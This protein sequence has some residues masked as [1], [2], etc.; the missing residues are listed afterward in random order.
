MRG[1]LVFLISTLAVLSVHA[2]DLRVGYSE[3]IVNLPEK[4]S[5]AGYI[6]RRLVRSSNAAYSKYFR[7][8]TGKMNDSLAKTIV[9][10]DGRQLIFMSTLEVIA[11]EPE[12]KALVEERLRQLINRPLEVNLFATHTHSGPG[13]FVKVKLW[14]QLATDYY[15]A[16]V[17]NHFAD[18]LVESAY[19]AYNSLEKVQ[20]SYVTGSVNGFVFNRRNG[21]YLNPQLNIVKFVNSNNKPVVSILNFPIHGTALGP[22]NLLVSGDLPAMVENKMVEKTNSPF[23]F[24]SGAA[25]DVGPK[26]DE[27]GATSF[28]AT[29]ASSP[30]LESIEKFTNRLADKINVFWNQTNFVATK[31]AIVRSFNIELPPA[32]ADLGSCIKSVLPKPFQW[33]SNFFFRVKLPKE[34][35][36]PMIVN[37]V[38]LAPLTFYMIPGEPIGEVGKEIEKFSV[39]NS[40]DNPMILAL[41][42]SYYGY[43]LSDKEFSRGGYETCNSF[44]GKTYG[45]LFL[46]G[47]QDAV[48]LFGLL[49][50]SN[51]F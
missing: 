49:V 41:A 47:L 1:I 50:K 6:Q 20:M 2:A 14:Q 38:H 18:S 25:G 10:D 26:I 21:S 29:V 4:I 24:F 13:G 11:I 45:S 46:S 12:M 48:N 34:L 3:K 36:R 7:A 51:R 16:D 31:P 44:Y 42:N 30:S 15:F 19:S 9:I 27:S 32:Q 40:F 33:V 28:N 37:M 17:F 22:E 43:I 8:S 5:L 39:E 35:D 23:M